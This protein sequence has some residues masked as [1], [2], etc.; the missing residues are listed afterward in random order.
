MKDSIREIT[1][2]TGTDDG[3]RP[4]R[5]IFLVDHNNRVQDIVEDGVR[6]SGEGF[7]ALPVAVDGKVFFTDDEG[8]IL[9]LEADRTFRLLHIHE[10]WEPTLAS[11]ALVDGRWYFRTNRHLLRG[12]FPAEP[13]GSHS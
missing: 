13:L 8:Q 4:G 6:H 2:I 7:S 9:V 11:P 5:Q 3:S 10:L 1:Q 12:R